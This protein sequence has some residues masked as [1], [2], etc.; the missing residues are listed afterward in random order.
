MK[1]IKVIVQGADGKMGGAII[2]AILKNSDFKLIPVSLT[3]P[4]TIEKGVTIDGVL[5]TLFTP[6]EMRHYVTS[7]FIYSF[8]PMGK[9]MLEENIPDIIVDFTHPKAIEYNVDFYTKMCLPFVLGTTGGDVDYISTKV[10][11]AGIN[12]VVAPNMAGEIVAFQMMMDWLASNFPGLFK[13]YDL[14]ITESHQKTKADTSGTAKAMI[15]TFNQ[16]GVPFTV[17]Q[18]DKKRTEKDYYLRGIPEEHWGGHG[19]HTYSLNKKDGSVDFTFTHN[20]RGREAYVAGTLSAIR[21]LFEKGHEPC[22]KGKVYS[23]ADVLRKK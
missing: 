12:A 11:E 20:V 16:L 19:Y 18:I 22:S 7:D 23:M 14:T 8:V 9:R 3:A 1:K 21:Y 2:R 10:E 6:A 5:I 15:K 13:D 4:E 17:D